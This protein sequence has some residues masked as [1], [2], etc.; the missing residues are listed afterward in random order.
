M[1]D[2]ATVRP[3]RII[4]LNG[5]SSSGKSSLAL[6]LQRQLDEPF[7]HWSIDHLLAAR[8]L[9]HERMAS[10]D[11]EWAR[12]RPAFFDGFHRSIPAL[13]AAGNDL[14]VEHIVETS[15]WMQRLVKLLAPF[16]VFHV[17][18]RCP[19]DELERRERERGDRRLGSAREDDATTHAF[20]AYDYEVRT[21]A[22]ADALAADVLRAWRARSHPGSFAR[23]AARA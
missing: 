12:M 7:W 20:G 9:P 19:V 4:L 13:A 15:G 6:A 16:D 11:F 1:S 3:G 5:A 22:P 14:I 17:G 10:G 8:V 23:M 18:V 2:D 21:T